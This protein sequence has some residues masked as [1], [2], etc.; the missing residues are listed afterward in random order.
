MSTEAA[1]T[2]QVELEEVYLSPVELI[3]AGAE[4]IR[5]QRGWLLRDQDGNVLV[6]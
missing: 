2:V 5:D 3:P 1:L 4:P 6:M